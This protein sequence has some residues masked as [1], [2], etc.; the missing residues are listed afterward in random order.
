M[1][2][3]IAIDTSKCTGCRMCEIAHSANRLSAISVMVIHHVLSFARRMRF[4]I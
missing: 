3:A 1:N 2:Y 4:N